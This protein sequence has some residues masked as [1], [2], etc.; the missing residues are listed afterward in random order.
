[1]N[2]LPELSLSISSP[3]YMQQHERLNPLTNFRERGS[4]ESYLSELS[5]IYLRV[6]SRL[7]KDG[8]LLI[9]AANLKGEHGVPFFIHFNTKTFPA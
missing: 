9:E 3:I 8:H 2:D 1:M 7:R 5:S 6:A 4:Y